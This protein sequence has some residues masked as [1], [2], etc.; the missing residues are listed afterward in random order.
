MSKEEKEILKFKISEGVKKFLQSVDNLFFI[1]R[2]KKYKETV[3]NKTIEEMQL[4]TNKIITTRCN[5][6]SYV[7]GG[8][9]A[10]ETKRNNVDEN[11]KNDLEKAAEKM[12]E[13]RRKNG[14][15]KTGALKGKETKLNDIDENGLN[16]YQRSAKKGLEKK[17]IKNIS[18]KAAETMKNTFDENGINLKEK[19]LKKRHETM[20][21]IDDDGLSGYQK[22]RLKQDKTVY[23]NVIIYNSNDEIIQEFKKSTKKDIFEQSIIPMTIF[24]Y[25]KGVYIIGKHTNKNNI[26]FEGFYIKRKRIKND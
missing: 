21:K 1:K 13:T 22:A 12:V 6:N 23:Y 2:S 7:T 24:W 19:R 3:N 4:W 10:A 14:S 20:S 18:L 8:I 15:F 5:N 17:D 9:K 26:K 11:G 25:L 16:S